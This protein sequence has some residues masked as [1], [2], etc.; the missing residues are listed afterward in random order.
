MASK[1]VIHAYHP[2][3]A[4]YLTLYL[5]DKVFRVY[6][7]EALEIDVDSNGR[8]LETPEFY[9]HQLIAQYGGLYGLVDVPASKTRTGIVLDVDAALGSA[10]ALL[11]VNRHR[12]I[13][14]WASDQIK[15][16]VNKNLPVLAPTG[17]VA[18]SIKLLDIDLRATY[19][20]MPIGWDFKPTGHTKANG[21]LLTVD[22]S[23]AEDQG[24]EIAEL[25]AQNAALSSKLDEVLAKFSEF[26]EHKGKSK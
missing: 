15:T 17:F 13:N 4:E 3:D 12:H 25:K 18:E 26:M 14:Q 19:N 1:Y 5:D 7:E 16:R 8:T 20:I 22:P 2:D 9:H 10:K 11:L 21:A 24:E 23:I 6:P